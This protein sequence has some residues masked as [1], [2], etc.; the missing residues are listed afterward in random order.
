MNER[1]TAELERLI[2]TLIYIIGHKSS[3]LDDLTDITI[4]IKD[5]G[6]GTRKISISTLSAEGE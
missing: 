1:E 6:N 5:N 2:D 3:I 4:K